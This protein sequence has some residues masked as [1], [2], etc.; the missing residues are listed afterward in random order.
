MSVDQPTNS[1]DQSQRV[2][3][4]PIVYTYEATGQELVAEAFMRIHDAIGRQPAP[5]LTSTPKP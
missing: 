4:A 5:A 1:A 2:E 3:P